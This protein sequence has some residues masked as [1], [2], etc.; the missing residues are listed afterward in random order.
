MTKI[1][2]GNYDDFDDSPRT[3]A[4]VLRW[5]AEACG[6]DDEAEEAN[7]GDAT[8]LIPATGLIEFETA[9]ALCE[10]IGARHQRDW[11]FICSVADRMHQPYGRSTLQKFAG[12]IHKNYDTLRRRLRLYRACREAG[13]IWA[14]RPKSWS[15]LLEFAGATAYGIDYL[16]RNPDTTETEARALA[17]ARRQGE[18]APRTAAQKEEWEQNQDA[19]LG[20]IMRAV[21][22]INNHSNFMEDYHKQP[23]RERRLAGKIDVMANLLATVKAASK[24]LPELYEYLR[25]LPARYV[26]HA[27][28]TTKCNGRLRSCH[29]PQPGA[30]Q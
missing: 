3:A 6:D 21:Q 7:G 10:P 25:T 12:R 20:D 14:L 13:T 28:A 15:V 27:P 30:V 1:E 22:L 2:A 29:Q 19:V 5:I 23:E 8:A 24:A 18:R 17:K 26:K 16:Q 4:E 9:V 11:L